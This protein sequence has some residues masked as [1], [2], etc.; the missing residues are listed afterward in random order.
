M[1]RED[2]D[3]VLDFLKSRK[4]DFKLFLKEERGLS[5]HAATFIIEDLEYKLKV[6]PHDGQHGVAQKSS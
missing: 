1:S 2:T 3:L 6:N 4:N 5:P